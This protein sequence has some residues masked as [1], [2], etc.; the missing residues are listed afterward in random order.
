MQETIFSWFDHTKDPNTHTHV[1]TIKINTTEGVAYLCK[2]IGSSFGVGVRKKFPPIC[3]KTIHHLSSGDTINIID[4][5]DRINSWDGLFLRYNYDQS[6]LHG[7][8]QYSNYPVSNQ[9][10]LEALGLEK[11]I[12]SIS[13]RNFGPVENKN[14][15]NLVGAYF[16][17]ENSLFVVYSFVN[18]G[19]VRC[20]FS[21]DRGVFRGASCYILLGS[22]LGQRCIV[23]DNLYWDHYSLQMLVWRKF[24]GYLIRRVGHVGLIIIA[25]L[26]L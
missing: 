12:R 18:N 8:V 3:L 13:E 20:V 11:F 10:N 22:S 14:D 5:C 26:C 1:D 15:E 7:S 6:C 21:C 25:E 9:D 23:Q 16:M 4:V 19:R 24:L 2:L 17:Y